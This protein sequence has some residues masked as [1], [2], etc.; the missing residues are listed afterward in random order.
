MREAWN[1]IEIHTRKG[2]L[3]PP[4]VALLHGRPL[5]RTSFLTMDAYVVRRPGGAFKNRA[6]FE[7][8]LEL[9]L[10]AF[11]GTCQYCELMGFRVELILV[12]G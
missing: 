6:E 2:K 7:D 12:E 4:C 3:K 9:E 10:L 8:W 5:A 1:Q 11:G